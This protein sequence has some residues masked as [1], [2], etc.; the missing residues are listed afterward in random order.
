[1]TYK[2]T[3]K[4]C[5]DFPVTLTVLGQDTSFLESSKFKHSYTFVSNKNKATNRITAIQN[6]QNVSTLLHSVLPSQFRYE[7][8][9]FKR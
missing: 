7:D 8:T 6:T 3:V 4:N 2:V 1:M 9:N 5:I